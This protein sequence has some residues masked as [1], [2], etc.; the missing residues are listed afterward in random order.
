MKVRKFQESAGILSAY[1]KRKRYAVVAEE[2]VDD[3][4]LV[5]DIGCGEGGVK[6]YLPLHTIYY[7]LD[8]KSNK[9]KNIYA[10]DVTK[11]FPPKV[12]NM[13]FDY[14]IS[15][16]FVEH[17]KD[18]ASFLGRCKKVLKDDGKIVV[19]TPHPI[20]RKVHEIGAALGLFSKE[21]A[22]E[23][24]KFLDKRDIESLSFVAGLKLIKYKRFLFGF[25][26][27]FVIKNVR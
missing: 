22:E 24:E 9:N 3:K 17:I 11:G 25:N 13:K 16:A 20:G 1:L 5:L 23:H 26:Q 12:S 15:L 18:V 7:G 8:I 10:C 21:A 19:T 27:L 2:I 14:I 6:E 4:R